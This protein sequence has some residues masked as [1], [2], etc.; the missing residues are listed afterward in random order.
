[1]NGT[2]TLIVTGKMEEQALATALNRAFS[3]LS[4]STKRLDGMTS[5]NFA[6]APTPSVKKDQDAMRINLPLNWL[7]QWILDE[8]ENP[9]IWP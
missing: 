3:E 8:K 4:F 7:R 5:V 9:K 6:K 1:M 2:V